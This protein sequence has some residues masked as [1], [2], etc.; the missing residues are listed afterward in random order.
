MTPWRVLYVNCYLCIHIYNHKYLL[1]LGP[2]SRS[3][4]NGDGVSPLAYAGYLANADTSNTALIE[5][6]PPQPA[7]DTKNKFRTADGSCNNL[8]NPKYGMSATPLKRLM[9]SKY[10]DGMHFIAYI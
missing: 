5:N 6:C 3:S 4:G 2:Q 7:C 10:D 9:P 1:A 8:K